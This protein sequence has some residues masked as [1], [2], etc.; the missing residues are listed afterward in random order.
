[1]GRGSSGATQR[2]AGQNVNPGDI[3]NNEEMIV[4]RGARPDEVDAVLTVARDLNNQYGADGI[5]YEFQTADMTK[6][7]ANVIAYYD[8]V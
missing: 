2:M 6:S 1:M 4:Q 8:G 3:S 5:V 7:A